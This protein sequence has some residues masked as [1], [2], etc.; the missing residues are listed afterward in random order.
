MKQLV[1]AYLS[2]V[3]PAKRK[4]LEHIRALVHE[5]VPGV[6]ETI[7]YGMPTFKINGKPIIHIAA[8]K[9]HM[10]IFP[11]G[12]GDVVTIPGVEAF[13]TSKGTLQFTE[14]KPLS[15]EMLRAIILLRLSKV[16]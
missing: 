6:E 1:D 4:H 3:E 13:R 14:E 16:R 12:D 2:G 15:D 7:S 8:F 5:L 9:Q 10:S 11:T